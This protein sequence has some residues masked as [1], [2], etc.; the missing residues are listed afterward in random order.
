MN[1]E[2]RKPNDTLP[3][4]GV[5]SGRTLRLPALVLGLGSCLLL[6][7][8][9]NTPPNFANMNDA[10]IL[11]YNESQ[12][13]LSQIHC[14]REATTSTYIRKRHCKTVEGWMR[15]NER[16]ADRLSVLNTGPVYNFPRS[17][18]D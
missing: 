17:I 1:T 11:A 8:C 16:E 7:A 14:V 5:K 3:P 10:E 9:E 12:P 2:N 18:R 4:A 13:L 6:S 15:H